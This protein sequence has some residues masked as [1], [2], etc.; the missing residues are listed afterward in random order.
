MRYELKDMNGAGACIHNLGR[1]AY[2]L[3]DLDAARA[4]QFQSLATMREV[5]A[6]HGVPDA[7]QALAEIAYRQGNLPEAQSFFSEACAR[8]SARSETSWQ[9][10][11]A[12]LR[13]GDVTL[14]LAELEA[15]EGYY[16]QSLA[17]FEKMGNAE[18]CEWVR[19]RLERA[20]VRHA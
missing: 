17:L 20:M 5:G 13:V 8:R 6:P 16:Q 18:G 12:L 10:A 15:A 19:G 1:I 2:C 4:L 7:M 14:E 9:H 3:G 11:Y